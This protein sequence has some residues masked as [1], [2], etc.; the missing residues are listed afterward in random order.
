MRRPISAGRTEAH[1]GG[2]TRSKYIAGVAACIAVFAVA[3]ASSASAAPIA[4]HF[5]TALS[6]S[7]PNDNVC[8]IDGSSVVTGTLN[9]QSFAD[10]TSW[11]EIHF[12]YVFTAAASGKSIQISGSDRNGGITTDNGDGTFTAISTFKGLPQKLSLGNGRTLSRDAGNV[13]FIQTFDA[14]GNLLSQVLSPL[15]GPHPSIADPN[16]FCDVLVPALT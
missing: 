9:V 3:M 15:H 16:L 4:S 13:T 5:H 7:N 11:A 8:G 10:G 14:D 1:T 6:D 2:K 12:A